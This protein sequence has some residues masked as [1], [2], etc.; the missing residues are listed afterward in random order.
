MSILKNTIDLW[1][2]RGVSEHRERERKIRS[3]GREEEVEVGR[4][5]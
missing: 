1:G 2:A 4:E 5:K 3:K